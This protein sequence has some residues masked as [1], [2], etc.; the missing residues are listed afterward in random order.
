M[1]AD[2]V[3]RNSSANLISLFRAAEEDY[4][5]VPKG[6]PLTPLPYTQATPKVSKGRAESPLVRPKAQTSPYIHAGKPLQKGAPFHRKRALFSRRSARPGSRG[7]DRPLIF[8][9]PESR[10]PLAHSRSW[11]RPDSWH[12][13]PCQSS[14]CQSGQRGSPWLRRFRGT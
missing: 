11:C 10:C 14:R 13:R 5:P 9:L 6:D 2:A 7:T 8:T 1:W 12:R 4:F 3:A